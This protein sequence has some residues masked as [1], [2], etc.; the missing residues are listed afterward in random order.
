VFI[1]L[2]LDAFD[3]SQMCSQYMGKL[4][5][6]D[7]LGYKADLVPRVAGHGKK[8]ELGACFSA[9]KHWAEEDRSALG[10]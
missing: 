1:K 2:K 8:V 7:I 6:F 5:D 10:Y 4:S 3:G 9:L